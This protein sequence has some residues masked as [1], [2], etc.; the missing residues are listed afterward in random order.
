MERRLLQQ[1]SVGFEHGFLGDEEDAV[2]FWEFLCGDQA[3]A[4]V[5]QLGGCDATD[6]HAAVLR[7]LGEEVVFVGEGS[8][9]GHCFGWAFSFVG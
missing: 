3:Y 4:S 9:V 2:V 8:F 7:P 6:F 5:G 1:G